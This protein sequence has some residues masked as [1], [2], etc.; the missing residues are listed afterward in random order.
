[1]TLVH[2]GNHMETNMETNI[3]TTIKKM[4]GIASD[5]TPFDTD[6]IVHINSALLT[7][8][9]IGIGPETGFR[10]PTDGDEW[11]DL[12]GSRTDLDA[13][14]DLIYLKVRLVFDPP[15]NSSLTDAIERQINNL[16]QRIALQVEC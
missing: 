2:G 10:I 3:L 13:V 15:A 7:L 14:K 12:L 6:I 1:M 4:L 8:T 5:Y 11:S 16:E 9:Q